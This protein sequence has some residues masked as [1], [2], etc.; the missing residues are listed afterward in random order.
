MVSHCIIL[1][2]R[3]L[4]FV[5]HTKRS[6]FPPSFVL[7][8]KHLSNIDLKVLVRRV[9]GILHWIGI[10]V[11]LVF[12]GDKHISLFCTFCYLVVY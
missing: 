4:T 10:F 1:L 5:F 12:G 7:T 6:R 9:V 8:Q 2:N 3:L 11:G